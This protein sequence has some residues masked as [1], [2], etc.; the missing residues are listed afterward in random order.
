MKGDGEKTFSWWHDGVGMW[1]GLLVSIPQGHNI[2]TTGPCL[3]GGDFPS[4]RS[5]KTGDGC[6]G[7]PAL[8]SRRIPV[9]WELG[10]KSSGFAQS[11]ELFHGPLWLHNAIS[12]LEAVAF[13]MPG[14]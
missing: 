12:Q 11:S 4:W 7:L 13:V 9:S 14:N 10:R 5:K 8:R 1:Y 6:W 2:D 3:P